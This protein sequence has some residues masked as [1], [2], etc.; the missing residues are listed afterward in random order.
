VEPLPLASANAQPPRGQGNVEALDPEV[1]RRFAEEVLIYLRDIESEFDVRI[2]RIAIDAPSHPRLDILPRRACETALDRR[3]IS[4]IATLN[5]ARFDENRDRALDHIAAG[6][7]EARLP[8]AN[9]IWM[10]V[11]FALFARLRKNWECIDVFPQAIAAPLG[12]AGVHKRFPD[13]LRAQL[14]GGGVYSL[15]ESF[16]RGVVAGNRV[17]VQRMTG[18][19]PISHLSLIMDRIAA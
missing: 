12:A 1:V 5:R 4:C 19:T 17:T 2:E 16:R 7:T 8:A 18:S 15:A 9:Q 6:G 13:G 11:G 10:L 14:S 3:E